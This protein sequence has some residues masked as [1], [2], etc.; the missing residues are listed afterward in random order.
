[1][2]SLRLVSICWKT[3]TNLEEKKIYLKKYQINYKVRQVTLFFNFLLLL[4]DRSNFLE[5]HHENCPLKRQLSLACRR[6]P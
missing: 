3:L 1:M 4:H 6:N 2:V 5:Y